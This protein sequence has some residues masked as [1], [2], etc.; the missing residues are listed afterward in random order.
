MVSK[1]RVKNI[2]EL[3]WTVNLQLT[4]WRLTSEKCGLRH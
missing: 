3:H 2:R 1:P 4:N